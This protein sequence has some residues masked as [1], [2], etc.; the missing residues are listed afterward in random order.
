LVAVESGAVPA[1]GQRRQL[2][3]GTY[4]TKREAE[5]RLAEVVAGGFQRPSE[6]TLGAYLCEEWLASKA[7]RSA[8]TRKQYGWAV[9]RLVAALGKARLSGLTARQVQ[10]LHDALRDEGLSS[11]SRQAVGKVLRMALSDAVKRGYVA[12]N[13]AEAVTLPNGERQSEILVWTRAQASAFLAAVREDRLFPV[14]AVALATGLRRAELCG[15]R[16]MDVDLDAGR[17]FVRQSITLD[18]YTVSVGRPKSRASV[19]TVGVDADT[20]AV[21]RSWREVQRRELDFVGASAGLVIT[22]PDGSL[23][24][25]QTL[26][27]QF[28]RAVAGSGLPDVGLHG[29]R[30]TH[31]TMLLEAGVPLKVVS[32]RLGHS[33]ISI[34]ADTY[35][36]VLDHMQDRAADAMR[37]LL[38]PLLPAGDGPAGC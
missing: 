13:V 32:E 25:P 4:R 28:K 14:W 10:G 11:R 19:R 9:D 38:S 31:A 16:W 15:L 17:L 2:S 7:E 23:V 27:L 8:A 20:V 34:T 5:R 21:L 33:T 24:H 35:Q 1:T 3:A 12:R 36:H 22:Q 6:R 30:H 29:L 37:G 18:G 26:A